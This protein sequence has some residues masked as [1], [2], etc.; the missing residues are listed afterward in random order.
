MH[1]GAQAVTK[2]KNFRRVG[3]P[4]TIKGKPNPAYPSQNAARGLNQQGESPDGRPTVSRLARAGENYAI[5]GDD[6]TGK[7]YVMQDAP[8]DRALRKR[9]ISGA[10]HSALQKYRHHWYHAGQ[11]P[12]VGSIDLNRVFSSE[13]G[14]V[15]GMPTSERQVFHRQ[16]W[17][18]AQAAL[19]HRPLIVV[20][21]VVCHENSLEVSGYAVGYGAQASAIRGAGRMLSEAGHVLAR[22][23][24]IG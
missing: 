5:G 3:I 1:H 11:A 6:R 16:R 10:E 9:I 21:N 20:D 17:R 22:L 15:A 2:T 23:W 24:G 8:L 18:E 12:H 13:G 19:G 14:N 7:R 4:A